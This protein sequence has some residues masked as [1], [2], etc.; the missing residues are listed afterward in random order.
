MSNVRWHNTIVVK[1]RL[2]SNLSRRHVHVFGCS[3]FFLAGFHFAPICT[4]NLIVS[5][6]FFYCTSM[7][8]PFSLIPRNSAVISGT[9]RLS[10]QISVIQ[11]ITFVNVNSLVFS[12]PEIFLHMFF[13]FWVQVHVFLHPGIFVLH[14]VPMYS[15]VIIYTRFSL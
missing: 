10:L 8:L 7:L 13:E 4:K 6:N 11:D 1:R 14:Y 3:T 5:S 12:N 9:T 2:S 15:R